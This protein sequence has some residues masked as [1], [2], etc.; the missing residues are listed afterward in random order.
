MIDTVA[1]IETVRLDV[2][3]IITALSL[4]I[5]AVATFVVALRDRKSNGSSNEK[6]VAVTEVVNTGKK[7]EQL[8][9]QVDFLFEEIGRLRQEKETLEKRIDKLTSELRNEREDHAKTKQRLEELLVELNEKNERIKTLEAELA[10][11]Q[12][13]K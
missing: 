6:A 4:V 11:I 1:A 8:I 7:V 3:A 9:Q 10:K 5:T 12:E 13:N 2:A